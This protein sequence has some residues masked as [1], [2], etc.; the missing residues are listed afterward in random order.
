MTAYVCPENPLRCWCE[1]WRPSD[2]YINYLKSSSPAILLQ[3][4][5]P[6]NEEPAHDLCYK[7]A[8]HIKQNL[9]HTSL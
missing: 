2:A 7:M 9:I 3:R 6:N 4:Q 8:D 1:P 5:P